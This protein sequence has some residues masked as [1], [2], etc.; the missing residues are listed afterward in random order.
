MQQHEIAY[1]AIIEDLARAGKILDPE[2]LAITYLNT[3]PD[4]YSSLIQSMEPVLATLT[5]QNI[6]AKVREEEQRLKNVENGSSDHALAQSVLVA[7]NNAQQ[8]Q[9]TSKSPKQARQKKGKCHHCGLKG[10]WKNECRK[11]IAEE[12]GLSNENGPAGNG[13]GNMGGTAMYSAA[14]AIVANIAVAQ[15]LLDK[16]STET[17]W[18]FDSGA[19]RQMFPHRKEFLEYTQMVNSPDNVVGI[20][21]NSLRVAGMGTVKIYDETGGF[22]I[23]QD[24]LHVPQLRNGLL[25]ITRATD[26]GFETLIAGKHLTFTDGNICIVAPIVNGLATLPHRVIMHVHDCMLQALGMAQGSAYGMNASAMLQ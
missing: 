22:S 2:D 6:K 3:L 24:V 5:S 8:G 20:G 12:R 9:P 13:T 16:T 19:N 26:Q 11:R 21:S 7:A 10:H 4:T 17:L 23:L 15:K 1:D 18:I 25:S 14:L